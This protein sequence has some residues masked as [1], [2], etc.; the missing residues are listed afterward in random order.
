MAEQA[1]PP[2]PETEFRRTEDFSSVYSNNVQFES[3]TWDLK[4]I[5]G[6]LN[7][8]GGKL[9]VDQH[10]SVSMS[11]MQAKVMSYFLRLFIAFYE[12]DNGTIRIPPPVLP[13]EPPPLPP[14][15]EN[16]PRAQA[17]RDYALK[18]REELM[19]A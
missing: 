6:E 17:V 11:W 19:K 15:Y 3:S 13:P 12:I 16:N 2:A 1:G 9:I 8:S 5:F 7:Q 14:E 18:M 4:A 10:T